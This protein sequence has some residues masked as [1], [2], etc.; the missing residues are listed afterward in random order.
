[1]EPMLPSPAPNL[2]SSPQMSGS[3]AG[4]EANSTDKTPET[5]ESEPTKLS[6]PMQPQ[7]QAQPQVQSTDDNTVVS[8]T[9]DD[10]GSAS[11]AVADDVDVIEKEWVDKA[12]KIVDST[13]DN[14]RAQEK[15]VS[16]LQAEYLM[17]RYGKQLK[18]TE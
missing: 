18:V 1:M 3:G 13:K 5:R 2:E 15:E 16:K 4:I 12:K 14:P 9:T 17:K 10:N 6:A 8:N 7:S 11:P